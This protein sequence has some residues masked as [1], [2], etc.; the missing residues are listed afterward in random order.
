MSYKQPVHIIGG[1]LFGLTLSRALR[2]HRIPSIIWEKVRERQLH[3]YGIT[4]HPSYYKPLANVLK[5]SHDKFRAKFAVDNHMGGKGDLNPKRMN[6]LGGLELGSFRANRGRLENFLLDKVQ[7]RRDHLLQKVEKQSGGSWVMDFKNGSRVKSA[8]VIVAD[9]VHSSTRNL[10]ASQNDLNILPFAAFSGKRWITKQTF[11]QLLAK[12]MEGATVLES[13]KD[14]YFLQISINR[15]AK[16]KRAYIKWVVSRPSRGDN[17]ILFKPNRLLDAALDIPKE[18]YSEV[19][20]L[21][22]LDSPWKEIFDVEKMKEDRASN[23]LMRSFYLERPEVRRL[24]HEGLFLVGDAVHAEPI[25]GG[26]GANNALREGVH[27]ADV[28][29]KDGI[30]GVGKGILERYHDWRE[31]VLRSEKLIRMMH[32]L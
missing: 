26:L 17:D 20:V 29:A 30:E 12:E 5:M 31:G 19:A 23:Y 3:D 32:G 2:A 18:L 21:Q 22:N 13:L 10:V 6:Q 15:I 28:I 25:L 24:Y 1:G 7:I 11:D 16:D 14:G 9:G 4:L 27:L 8:H